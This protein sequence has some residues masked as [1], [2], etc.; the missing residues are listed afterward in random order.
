MKKITV[1]PMEVVGLGETLGR[2]PLSVEA[3]NQMQ[4]ICV[5]LVKVESIQTTD[6]DES[7]KVEKMIKLYCEQLR[8]LLE[9]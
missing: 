6:F 3:L 4:D 1:K 2:K 7:Y 9:A 8:K 5:R